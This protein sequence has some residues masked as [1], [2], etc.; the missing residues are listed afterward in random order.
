[1]DRAIEAKSKRN[2]GKRGN[3]QNTFKEARDQSL[4]EKI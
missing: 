3:A 4:D 1:M 2:S